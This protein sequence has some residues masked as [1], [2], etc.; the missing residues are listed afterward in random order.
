MKIDELKAYP[1]SDK[2]AYLLTLQRIAPEFGKDIIYKCNYWDGILSGT[3]RWNGALFNFESVMD[4]FD[5]A[6]PVSSEMSDVADQFEIT[7]ETTRRY[8]AVYVQSDSKMRQVVKR[9]V[10]FRRNVNPDDYRNKLKGR[11]M[12]RLKA[13]PGPNWRSWYDRRWPVIPDEQYD[14]DVIAWFTI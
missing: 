12:D 5:L 10:S 11:D 2:F 14:G 13:R 1:P 7:C 4:E 9:H 8:Y 3:L 6:I